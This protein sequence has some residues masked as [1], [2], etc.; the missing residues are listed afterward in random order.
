[1]TGPTPGQGDDPQPWGGK[2]PESR[3][4]TSWDGEPT[5]PYF[6]DPDEDLP[7]VG[8]PP[9]GPSRKVLAGI[10]AGVV[11]VVGAGVAFW[12]FAVGPGKGTTPAAAAATSQHPAPPPPARPTL[13]TAP[14]Q[15]PVTVPSGTPVPTATPTGPNAAAA[16]NVGM[17]FD[18]VAGTSPGTVELNPVACAGNRAVFVINDVV[19]SAADCDTGQGAADY[20]NHGYEVPDETADVAY[21]ASLVVPANTCFVLGASAPIARAACGSGPNVV[22]VTAIESAPTAAKACT[23]KTDPDV[24]FYQAPTSGQFACVTR[25]GTVPTTA[26][27]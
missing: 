7:P 24:W 8:M 21:C 18:E 26:H 19:A 15:A 23:D 25:P 3:Y 6:A 17:C 9:P 11:I 27:R 13:T 4:G 2:P 16:Y 10:A 22:R 14:V 12:W 20:H 1:M 5:N